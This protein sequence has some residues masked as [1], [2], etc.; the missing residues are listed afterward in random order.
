LDELRESFKVL[1]TEKDILRRIEEAKE[2]LLD[3]GESIEKFDLYSYL[4]KV[5]NTINKKK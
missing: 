4:R 3:F 5:E 2:K 1:K